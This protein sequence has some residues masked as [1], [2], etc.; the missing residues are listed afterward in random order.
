MQNYMIFFMVQMKKASPTLFFTPRNIMNGWMVGKS[1]F[2]QK[3]FA[4]R[5]TVDDFSLSLLQ[6]L[7][8][9]MIFFLCYACKYNHNKKGS[10]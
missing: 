5:Y 9:T 2:E 3:N 8:M 6:L 7:M 1:N 4:S 10:Y